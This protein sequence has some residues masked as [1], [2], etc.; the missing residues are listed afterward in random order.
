MK[1]KNK[2]SSL[3]GNRWLAFAILLVCNALGCVPQGSSTTVVSSDASSG[4]NSGGSNAA[5]N[6]TEQGRPPIL[7]TVTISPE[8]RVKAAAEEIPM[9]LVQGAWKDYSIEIEN[10]AGITG[11]LV[12]E[13]E[14]LLA[15]AADSSRDRWLQ[16][17]LQ[18]DRPLSGQYTEIRTLRI[19]SRDSGIRTAILNFNAGQGTQDLG[20]RSDVLVTFKVLGK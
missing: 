14:Q 18:P 12:I 3:A 6:L 8:S 13:S 17:E 7:I 10:A 5:S 2:R 19:K 20:F 15:D 4:N 16:I 9:E 11:P 1:P